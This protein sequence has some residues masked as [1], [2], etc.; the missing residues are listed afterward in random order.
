L[1][2]TAFVLFKEGNSGENN[3]CRVAFSMSK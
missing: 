1:I 3:N 2:L